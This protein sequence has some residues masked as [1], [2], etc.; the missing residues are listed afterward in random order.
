MAN[1]G[2]GTLSDPVIKT[3]ADLANDL[4]LAREDAEGANQGRGRAIFL[5]G[6]GCSVTAGIPAA[7]GVAKHCAL[8]LARAY[9]A[10]QFIDA[11]ANA[12]L[13]WLQKSNRVELV[14]DLAPKEDGSHWGA[15]YS[16]FFEFHLK[17]P[18]QQ[19]EVINEIIDEANDGLNWAHACLGE[20]VERRYVHTVLTTNFDQ[21]VLQGIIR[22]GILPVTADGL[23]ALNRI[24]GRPKRPQVVHLHGSMHTYNLRNSRAALNETSQDPGALSMVHGLLQQCD[25]LVVVGYAGGEEGVMALLRDAAKTMPQLVIYWVTYQQGHE[26]LSRNA[27]ELLSG[28]NKFSIWGGSADKFFGDLMAELRIGQPR[29]VADPISVLKAQSERLRSPEADLEDVRILVSA[30]KERVAFADRPESRWPEDDQTKVRAAEKRARGEFLAARQLLEQIDL[31][32]HLDAA[33]LHA[34][35]AHS[36]FE[37]DPANGADMLTSA[38]DEFEGLIGKTEGQERL[39]NI[40]SLCAALLDRSEAAPEGE[41]GAE[42]ALRRVVELVRR[43]LPTYSLEN[44]SLGAAR[45]NLF[46][47]L[48]LQSLAERSG[49][50]A[51]LAASEDAYNLAIGGLT[52][53]KDPDGRLIDAKSGLAAVLQVRGEAEGDADKLRKAVTLH[54]ELADASRS[55]EGSKEEAG[56]LE[57]LAGSLMSLAGAVEHDEAESLYGEAKSALERVIKIHQRQADS[58]RELAARHGLDDV[59][60]ALAA[61]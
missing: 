46:L 7:P 29:W 1:L 54:R 38:I 42:Q 50:Q 31:S 35:N 2:G 11:E 49:D 5:V 19:R 53:N 47:A 45:L 28:E 59:E 25:L 55:T 36:L 13:E 12:A 48:A 24:T 52:V 37:Q 26:M 33:R 51:D 27:R 39:D 6:A 56:P 17:S 10:G 43:W 4:I 3:V 32:Q 8:K 9:S 60:A 14:G 57:N 40:L 58:E 41:A 16:Y 30:F 23:E 18:N 20:L 44:N 21:L 61:L 22:T 15:L 34:L